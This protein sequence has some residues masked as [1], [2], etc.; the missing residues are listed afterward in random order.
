MALINLL[1]PFSFE[2]FLKSISKIQR[3][4]TNN[5]PIIHRQY[6]FVRNKHII[7]KITI[8][9]IQHIEA[10]GDFVALHTAA[11]QYIANTSL[12]DILLKIGIDFIRCH[13]SFIVNINAIEKINGN[14]I[15]I[16][17]N[18]IPI[19]RTFKEQLLKRLEMI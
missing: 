9:D 8:S 3:I 12:Q 15:M 19:G 11:K 6:L 7:Q 14:Q 5:N 17:K 13:K 18:T 16:G 4:A 1:K 2:R 10:K